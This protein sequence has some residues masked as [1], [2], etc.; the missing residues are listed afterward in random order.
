MFT[1]DS[2][3]NLLCSSSGRRHLEKKYWESTHLIDFS[4][5]INGLRYV[6]LEV[7]TKSF[8]LPFVMAH[9]FSN[10][11]LL[12]QI[13]SSSFNLKVT[14]PLCS[15][16]ACYNVSYML[17]TTYVVPI[18]RMKREREREIWFELKATFSRQKLF[19]FTKVNHPLKNLGKRETSDGYFWNPLFPAVLLTAYQNIHAVAAMRP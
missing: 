13:Y 18:S 10:V 11:P 12:L 1:G 7:V 15:T 6:I 8:F 9:L 3:L 2:A 17:W 4:Y 5:Q 19:F 16:H 14:T